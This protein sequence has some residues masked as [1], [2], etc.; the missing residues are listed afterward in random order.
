[1]PVRRQHHQCHRQHRHNFLVI[2][3]LGLYQG[4]QPRNFPCFPLLQVATLHFG[5]TCPCLEFA[6]ADEQQQGTSRL[7]GPGTWSVLCLRTPIVV[8]C[9]RL[10]CARL[11][12]CFSPSFRSSRGTPIGLAGAVPPTMAWRA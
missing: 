9:E 10:P 2:P 8:S 1:M 5:G 7:R 6:P 11:C 3:P 12:C 4:E